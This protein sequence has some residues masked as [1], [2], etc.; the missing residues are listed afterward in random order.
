MKNNL[1]SFSV[2]IVMLL[3]SSCFLT[4]AQASMPTS[5]GMKIIVTPAKGNSWTN[6]NNNMI[7]TLGAITTY[8]TALTAKHC[9]GV[10]SKVYVG[11]TQIGYIFS[12]HPYLDISYIALTP[13][14]KP[15]IDH[16][17]KSKLVY[18]ER[19]RKKGATTGV[20][21]GYVDSFKESRIEFNWYTTV[22]ARKVNLYIRYGDSGAPVY[23][24]RGDVVAIVSALPAPIDGNESFITPLSLT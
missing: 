14:T 11:Y 13:N 17:N 23:N 16:V 2:L 3:L 12:V 22:S 15:K 10:G 1:R 19:I 20:T 18:G 9:G 21:R 5:S 6:K 7:C 4:Q 24:N 8:K